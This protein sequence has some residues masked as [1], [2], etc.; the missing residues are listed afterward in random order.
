MKNQNTNTMDN[1]KIT[2][3]WTK[4]NRFKLTTACGHGGAFR[5][6]AYR[7]YVGKKYLHVQ[8]I[9]PEYEYDITPTIK[10]I[11]GDHTMEL[12]FPRHTKFS[13]SDLVIAALQQ[14]LKWCVDIRVNPKAVA[15]EIQHMTCYN[16][17]V[18]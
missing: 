4:A 3:N 13:K 8:F 12:W 16:E 9:T 18:S 2:M 17:M 6:T 14:S 10:F 1:F 11:Y 7:K 15:Q 5:M